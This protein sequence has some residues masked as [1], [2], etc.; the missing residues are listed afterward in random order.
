[1][2]RRDNVVIDRNNRGF[3]LREG[4][5]LMRGKTS[6][7]NCRVAK[8]TCLCLLVIFSSYANVYGAGNENTYMFVDCGQTVVNPSETTTICFDLKYHIEGTGL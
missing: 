6:S 5:F 1:M 3:S 2:K 8:L 7:C 4:R